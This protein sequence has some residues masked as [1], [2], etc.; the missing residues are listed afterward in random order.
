MNAKSDITPQDEAATFAVLDGKITLAD[1]DR[2][3]PLAAARGKTEPDYRDRA[4][5]LT[6]ELQGRKPGYFLLW[7]HFAKV[8]KVALE[9]DFHA[10]G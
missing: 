5:K 4:R 6:A 1:L 8:T 3:Y 9:R 7:R 10:L 2:L